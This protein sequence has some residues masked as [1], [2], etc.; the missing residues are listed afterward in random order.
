MDTGV[1]NG[2]LAEVGP[3]IEAGA[4]TATDDGTFWTFEFEEEA[5]LYLERSVREELLVLSG[6]VAHLPEEARARLFETLLMYNDQAPDSGGA[7][8]AIDGRD[9]AVVLSLDIF[10]E[11]ADPN[12]LAALLQNF[13][14]LRRTWCRV[15][16]QWPGQRTAAEEQPDGSA[17]T[18]LR[19]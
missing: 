17:Y 10:S 19:V 2:I 1:F 6:E 4:I 15:V 14:E 11:A 16:S 5:P 13:R 9:G 7:R 12:G 3:L 8:F 18:G